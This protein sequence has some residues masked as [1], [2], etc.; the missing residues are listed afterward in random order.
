MTPAQFIKLLLVSACLT[1]ACLANADVILDEDALKRAVPLS[2]STSFFEDESG[3]L[4][5]SDISTMTNQFSPLKEETPNFGFTKSAYWFRTVVTNSLA[6]S[7]G[8]LLEI[9]YPL[10]DDIVVYEK[11]Q[12]G[13]LITHR[14]G[15]NQPFESREIDNRNFLFRLSLDADAPVELIIRVSSSSSMQVPIKIWSFDSYA[16][17]SHTEHFMLGLYYGTM[18]ALFAYNLMLIFW[19]RDSVYVY[20]AGYLACYSIFQLTLNGLAFK[21]LWPE[22]VWLAER[23]VLLFLC[24]A[25]IF[26][27]K[28]SHSLLQISKFSSTLDKAYLFTIGFFITMIPFSIFADYQTMIQL[29]SVVVVAACI[30]LLFSAYRSLCSGV[31]T[32]IYYLMAFCVF[33]VGIAI[34][35]LK[36]QGLIAALNISEYAI[37]VASTIGAIL[38]SF[39]LSHRFK[40]LKEENNRMQTEAQE[41]LERSVTE[42]TKELK[43]VLDELSIANTRLEGLN[44]TDTLTGVK[45]RAYFEEHAEFVWKNTDRSNEELAIMMLDVDNFKHIND[46]YG[47]LIGDEVLISVAQ[48]IETALTRSTD[49]MARYGGEEFIV[50]LPT[51]V[52]DGSVSIAEK[53][54]TTVENI[55]T[56]AIGLTQSV[57]ISIGVTLERPSSNNTTLRDAI[58]HADKALYQ[59]KHSGK[60]CVVVYEHGVLNAM[61]S[62][63][64]QS[65]GMGGIA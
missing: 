15:D 43:S 47:H 42:R 14:A 49:Q 63:A 38:L 44:N 5:Y 40:V 18:A 34:Y 20:F 13:Q 16:L 21:F 45:S 33:L 22:S 61:G 11:S 17:S 27:S 9:A 35:T 46:N 23:A 26:A 25:A 58:E 4:K 54:R 1:F 28:F 56:Q 51:A 39:A 64:Q 57:T 32:A 60:N 37:M 62:N 29:L 19:I 6:D 65:S 30:L 41:I 3:S 31:S 10:L 7:N 8:W 53:I 59:A 50:I 36:S 12:N 2:I 52:L 48:A 24:L 55:D